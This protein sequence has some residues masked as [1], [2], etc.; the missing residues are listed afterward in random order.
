M[1]PSLVILVYPSSFIPFLKSIFSPYLLIAVYSL[2][3]YSASFFV[4]LCDVKKYF[5]N[6][7]NL[8]CCHIADVIVFARFPFI[9]FILCIFCCRSD[10]HR[11]RTWSAYSYISQ[12]FPSQA[13]C[14]PSSFLIFLLY[15][16][17]F[18]HLSFLPILVH[19]SSCDRTTDL[20][21]CV[22]L[23][24]KNVT[25]NVSWFCERP[26]SGNCQF[27]SRSS[28]I[29]GCLRRRRRGRGSRSS[30]RRTWRENRKGRTRSRTN[31]R[32]SKS[33]R[34]MKE[35]AKRRE[36]RMVSWILAWR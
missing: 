27:S 3:L 24:F 36:R 6:Y 35:K 32:R 30:S 25:G 14:F 7:E 16:P 19:P 20:H 23:A 12:A 17:V 34:R 33:R 10:Y 1:A 4:F 9:F 2:R 31:K 5:L 18:H 8:E 29:S 22:D 15:S 11:H 28:T 26:S 13:K 21:V